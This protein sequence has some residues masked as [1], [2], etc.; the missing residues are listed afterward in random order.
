MNQLPY[1][2]YEDLDDCTYTLARDDYNKRIRID[3]YYGNIDS[4]LNSAEEHV[5]A[6]NCEKLIFKARQEDFQTLLSRNFVLEAK[7]DKYYLGSDMYFFCKYYTSDRRKS[8]YWAE[9]D[10]LLENIYNNK[11]KQKPK[12]SIDQYTLKIC[13]ETDADYLAELYSSVFKIYPVPLNNPEYI[14]KCMRSGS[15]YMGFWH[16]GKI[17]S[18]VCAEMNDTYHNAEITDCATLPEY[19]QFGLMQ[20]L[21]AHI[22]KELHKKKIFCLY[23]IARARSYG[24]NAAFYRLGYEYRGRLANNCYIYEDIEDMNVWVKNI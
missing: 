23:S 8:D 7:V 10:Y 3:E 2:I 15:V 5:V 12:A 6:S 9:E 13:D 11:E 16:N 17:M 22:E 21:I 19:R 24:M 1:S 14:K 18:S 4:V 20:I